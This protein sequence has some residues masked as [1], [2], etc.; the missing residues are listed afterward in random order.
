[1]SIRRYNVTRNRS[2]AVGMFE[3]KLPATARASGK[4]AHGRRGLLKRQKAC[5]SAVCFARLVYSRFMHIAEALLRCI[6]GPLTEA[7]DIIDVCFR[8]AFSE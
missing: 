7:R 6:R 1:M 8:V 4:R 5:T 3:G 2:V